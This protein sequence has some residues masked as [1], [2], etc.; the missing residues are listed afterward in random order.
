MT[1][2]L[3]IEP[4]FTFRLFLDDYV[5]SDKASEDRGNRALKANTPLC[6]LNLNSPKFSTQ[7]RRLEEFDLFLGKDET[8]RDFSENTIQPKK[9][10]FSISSFLAKKE[11]LMNSDLSTRVSFGISST[12]LNCEDLR[13]ALGSLH[14]DTLRQKLMELVD[15]KKEKTF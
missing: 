15:E 7:G 6:G 2:H 9:D 8:E 11:N 14:C 3:N 12:N 13:K 10:G 1:D 4:L 5:L